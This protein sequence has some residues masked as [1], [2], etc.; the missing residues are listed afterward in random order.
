MLSCKGGVVNLTPGLR[1]ALG[2]NL[3]MFT[4]PKLRKEYFSFF[5][6]KIII[7]NPQEDQQFRW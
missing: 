7:L 4:V 6:R 5:L 3:R 1:G 2:N